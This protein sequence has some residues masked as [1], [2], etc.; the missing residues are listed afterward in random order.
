[1][2]TKGL[3]FIES[4]VNPNDTTYAAPK[5]ELPKRYELREQLRVY[6]QGSKG[7]CV[8]CTVAEMYN[9]YCKSKGRE[10]SIGFEYLYDQRSDKTIDGMMP[11]E[12]FEILKGEHRVEVFARIGSLDALKKSV[13][14]NGA[15]LIAMNV[16]SY[17]DDFWNGDE[18]MGGHA[19]AVVGYD[20]TGLII[21]TP[22]EHRLVGVVTL[23]FHTVS[24]T[25]FVRLG[26][27]CLKPVSSL[28]IEH[29]LWSPELL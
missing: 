10:P 20:E 28:I 9:F 26:H 22:G 7:S 2:I 18:F 16:F 14:T 1:M 13:L 27:F 15:A 23:L 12:A 21:K 8:S 5:I 17:N 3:G 25:K 11:R 19:V 29:F 24:S 6:D 4:G